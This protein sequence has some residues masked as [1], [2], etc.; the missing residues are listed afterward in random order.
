[1]TSHDTRGE[2]SA[3][4]VARLAES[5]S[6]LD[7][8]L[9]RLRGLTKE[10]A[11]DLMELADHLTRELDSDTR[12]ALEGIIKEITR[13]VEEAEERLKR[14]FEEK[15]AKELERIRRQA[16]ERLGEA[17]SEVV[18]KLRSLLAGGASS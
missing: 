13:E 9:A 10:K 2:K 11:R 1:M 4:P 18:A 8:E 7:S 17:V 14:E 6:W 5:V 15:K 3:S 12:L 16:E